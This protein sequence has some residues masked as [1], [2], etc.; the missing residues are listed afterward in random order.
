MQ[1][2]GVS[3]VFSRLG[4]EI[5]ATPQKFVSRRFLAQAAHNFSKRGKMIEGAASDYT[6]TKT[7]FDD[8]QGLPDA[9]SCSSNCE[10]GGR[11]KLTL[12]IVESMEYICA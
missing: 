5:L 11:C 12:T 7:S 4:S 9:V 1:S 10:S 6:L 8:S 3:P 2:A